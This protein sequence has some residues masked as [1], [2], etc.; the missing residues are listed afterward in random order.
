MTQP[1]WYLIAEMTNLS[2]R[3]GFHDLKTSRKLGFRS[4]NFLLLDNLIKKKNI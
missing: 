3:F 2:F 1:N 4:F